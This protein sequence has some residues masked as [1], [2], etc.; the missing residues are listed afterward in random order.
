MLRRPQTQQTRPGA[1]RP[2]ELQRFDGWKKNIN[3]FL[4]TIRC[5]GRGG[6]AA[7]GGEVGA[8]RRALI[9]TFA[10]LMSPLRPPPHLPAPR[11]AGTAR[12]ALCSGRHCYV[13]VQ[14]ETF[15][16]FSLFQE[17]FPYLLTVAIIIYSKF[18]CSENKLQ[19]QRGATLWRFSTPSPSAPRLCRSD[20][21]THR[22]MNI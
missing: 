6:R 13:T 7:G 5:W 8:R 16:F 14:W 15:S 9:A 20:L 10:L 19:E 12:T 4:A 2:A 17:I 11:C 3:R 1:L 18:E 22:L 21:G